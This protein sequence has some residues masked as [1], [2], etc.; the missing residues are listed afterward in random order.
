[1]QP[2]PDTATAPRL[3]GVI[4]EFI[5][6]IIIIIIYYCKIITI[7]FHTHLNN[8]ICNKIDPM[9]FDVH[10]GFCSGFARFKRDGAQIKTNF[11]LEYVYENKKKWSI[12]HKLFSYLTTR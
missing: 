5:E 3:F 11:K 8:G 12:L 7:S 1:M 2:R 4:C 9:R 10:Y 6:I